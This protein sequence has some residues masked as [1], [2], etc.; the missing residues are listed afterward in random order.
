MSM[1]CPKCLSEAK[2]KDSRRHAH[3]VIRRYKCLKC[4][5]R[6]TTI[7]STVT[8][9]PGMDNKPANLVN[10][11]V[12]AG[13]IIPHLD[14]IRDELIQKLEKSGNKP[15]RK[16]PTRKIR[17]ELE[18]LEDSREGFFHDYSKEKFSDR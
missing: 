5:N 14:A 15:H 6:W 13:K 4:E 10:I 2:C 12:M 9:V 1:D 18:I 7:E 3:G 16:K 8:V 17:N 11:S